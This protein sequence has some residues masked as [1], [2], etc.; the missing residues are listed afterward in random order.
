MTREQF[1][2]K[3]SGAHYGDAASMEQKLADLAG[4]IFNNYKPVEVVTAA[5]TL[6]A[7][8][9]GKTLVLN[10]AAGA[11]LTL[12]AVAIS[13]GFHLKVIVGAAF[14]TTA[15]TIKAATN[16]IQGGAI[17]NST[18]VPGVDENTITFAHAAETVGD[19]IELS[20]DGTNW[21]ANGVAA[22]AGGITFTAP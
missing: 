3:Y 14:A 21:Y 1:I 18:F 13:E 6:T 5:K 20:C 12:P 10:A 19:F 15:W 7:D 4:L 8:D 22:A 9:S 2:A 11:E 17:V 16:K